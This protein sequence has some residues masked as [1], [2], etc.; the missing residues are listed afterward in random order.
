[1]L[2][3]YTTTATE[4]G[5]HHIV[6]RV[7]LHGRAWRFRLLQRHRH[8]HLTI[9]HSD[10]LAFVVLP[11]V[12]N[13]TLF[14]TG[15]MLAR[16]AA[17]MSPALPRLVLDIG[18]GSGIAAVYVARAGGTVVATD[19]NPEAVRCAR[20]NALLNHV[21]DRVD[22]RLGDLFA[23]V[24]RERFELILFNPPYFDGKPT[25]RWELAWRAEG[26]IP[27]F[28][29]QLPDYLLPGGRALLV[30]STV[31]AGAFDALAASG[32]RARAVAGRQL[33]SERLEIVEV[34]A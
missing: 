3:R 6:K 16:Y 8:R 10:G 31:A 11:D 13:P 33:L 32:L 19:I 15:D 25:E 14:H 12:F 26:V 21:E 9:E 29:A 28:L 5:P 22:V 7:A 20:I 24:A 30:L 23:P 4:A 18:C 2:P 17:S 34:T 27:R 1:M